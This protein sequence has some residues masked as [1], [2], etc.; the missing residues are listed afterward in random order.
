MS[1]IVRGKPVKQPAAHSFRRSSLQPPET[2]VLPK[3]RRK[4]VTAQILSCW[5][6]AFREAAERDGA[7]NLYDQY[8][9]LD[10]IYADGLWED[11]ET[12]ELQVLA[13]PISTET[14][15]ANTIMLGLACITY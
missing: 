6:K 8:T 4:S 2:P 14:L 15:I 11:I 12:G 5:A 10:L 7:R 1:A 13:A 3:R 9:A